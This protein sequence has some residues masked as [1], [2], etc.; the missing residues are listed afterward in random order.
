MIVIIITI[1]TQIRA[2]FVKAVNVQ[3][4]VSYDVTPCLLV[5]AVPTFRRNLLSL[6][7]HGRRKGMQFVSVRL[8]LDR[9]LIVW[10]SDINTTVTSLA[11]N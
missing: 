2:A 11:P 10:P 8:A 1:I 5:G 9:I 4:T 7:A 3:I 6:H